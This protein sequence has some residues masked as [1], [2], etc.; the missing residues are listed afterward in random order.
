MYSGFDPFK[1]LRFWCQKVLPTV[2]DDSLSYYEAL[3]KIGRNVND[4]AEAINNIINTGSWDA[5]VAYTRPE[6]FGAVGDGVADD[7]DAVQSALNE[8]ES[9]HKFVLLSKK[10]LIGKTLN[11]PDGVVVIG[12]YGG[13]LVSKQ[14]QISGFV[15]TQI[16]NLGNDDVFINVVFDGNAPSGAS[17]A[18]GDRDNHNALIRGDNLNNLMFYGCKFKNYDTN[19][20]Q[21]VSSIEYVCVGLRYCTNVTF[22]KC[23]FERIRRECIIL[24]TCENVVIDSCTFNTGDEAGVYTEI[25]IYKGS[26]FQILNSTINHGDSVSTSPINAMGDNITIDNC[27]IIAK[28][29][30]FGIDYGNEL[31][32]DYPLDGLSISNCYIQTSISAAGT[33]ET[34]KHDNI[35]IYN[36]VIDRTGVTT[37]SGQLML[38]AFNGERIKVFNNEFRGS[39]EGEKYAIRT[40]FTDGD[41]E[42]VNNIFDSKGIRTGNNTVGLVVNNN[43][44]NDIGFYIANAPEAISDFPILNCRFNADLGKIASG[45]YYYNVIFVGCYLANENIY[46]ATSALPHFTHYDASLSYVASTGKGT[47]LPDDED[48]ET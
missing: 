42:I 10:Y 5:V 12:Q 29:S 47:V 8:G 1:P 44:F 22:E 6:F 16:M 45:V 35:R 39:V 27:S 11:V 17:Q 41:I 24:G 2:Y 31:G 38:Y 9:E 48:D 25:G 21:Y 34:I 28:A 36:N 4:L 40:S 20:S 23:R 19:W 7:S 18:Q 26:N 33:S 13:S 37:A 46:W 32:E 3:C 30:T 15:P 14:T 43:V